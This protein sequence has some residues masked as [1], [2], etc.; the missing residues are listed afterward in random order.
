MAMHCSEESQDLD[1][2]KTDDLRQELVEVQL[3]VPGVSSSI[4]FSHF[5][6]V[7]KIV[8]TSLGT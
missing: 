6:N 7:L 5:G 8:P 3:R 2:M 4:S 1:D